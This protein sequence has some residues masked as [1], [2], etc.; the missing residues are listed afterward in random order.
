MSAYDFRKIGHKLVDEIAGFLES[1]PERKVTESQSVAEIQNVLGNASLPQEGMDSAQLLKETTDLLVDHSLFNGHPRFWGYVTSSA[2][3]IGILGDF[4]ASAVNQNVGAWQLSPIASE[5]EAQTI[6]WIAEFIGYNTDCGGL[7]VSGGNMANFVGFL[8]GRK[9]KTPWDVRK[10]GLQNRDEQVRVYCSDATHTWVHKAADLFGLGTDAIR[11]IP[12]DIDQHMDV[13]KLEEQ[14]ETDI[15]LGFIPLLVA[16]SAGTVATGAVDPI[17]AI[18]D[19]CENYQLWLHVDGAYGAM[20]AALPEAH[21][22]LKA[23]H[24][25]DSV[26]LDPHKWLY[27]PIEAGCTLVRNAQDLPDTFSFQPD[28]YQF[29]IEGDQPPTNYYELGLQNTR[30]FRAL[31]VWLAF[32][33]VGSSAF[34]ET[35]RQDIQLAQAMYDAFAAHEELE[36]FTCHLSITTFRYVPQYL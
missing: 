22:D 27:S 31:K 16:A 19:L 11:W 5:I 15:K 33:Q 2:A 3:P 6:R 10:E 7:M 12:S 4:L 25:A 34:V 26:A 17:N 29:D 20:A 24:R 36:A 21:E 23:I 35:I 8:A 18:A 1:L 28:Y 30:G 14:I 9:S 32:R 13:A